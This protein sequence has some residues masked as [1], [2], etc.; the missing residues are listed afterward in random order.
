MK[1]DARMF[2]IKEL[3][4]KNATE[5][6]ANFIFGR[7]YYPLIFPPALIDRNSIRKPNF[8]SLSLI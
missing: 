2:C 5:K 7:I 1:G 8:S 6:K 4:N 3:L